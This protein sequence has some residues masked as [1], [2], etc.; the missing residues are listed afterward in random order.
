MALATAS[1]SSQ[2]IIANYSVD[3]PE[4]PAQ[5]LPLPAPAAPLAADVEE[6]VYQL[7]EDQLDHEKGPLLMPS[8]QIELV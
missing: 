6:L 4:S 8:L 5:A 2:N 1:N 7:E 3:M